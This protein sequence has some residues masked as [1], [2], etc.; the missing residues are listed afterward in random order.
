MNS[1]SPKPVPAQRIP[2]S[3]GATPSP[4]DDN[5]DLSLAPVHPEFAFSDGNIQLQTTNQ[6]FWVHEYHLNKFDAFAALIQAAKSS[7]KI[8]DI[9]RRIVVA[10][11]KK[12]NGEDIYNTLKV[13]YAS[14]IDGVPDFNL[15]I[16]TSTLR[17]ATLFDYPTLRK[18]TMSKLE[19][20][21]I[22]AIQRIQLSDEFSLPSW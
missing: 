4:F 1:E 13:I 17:I 2:I 16:L 19:G 21:D 15:S 6:T 5:E 3:I 9:D 10:C 14:H 12:I 8:S 20:K 11:D 7:G 22:P 18:F